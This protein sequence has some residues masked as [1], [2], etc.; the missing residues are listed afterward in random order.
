[1]SIIIDLD[2]ITADGREIGYQT[3]GDW[4]GS[5][6]AYCTSRQWILTDASPAQRRAIAD[7]HDITYCRT[8]RQWHV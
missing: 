4:A 3:D 6:P 7:R 2:T 5:A 1:M 8:C